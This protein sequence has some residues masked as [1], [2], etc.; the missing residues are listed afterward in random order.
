MVGLRS[1]QESVACDVHV[2]QLRHA[3]PSGM[4]RFNIVCRLQSVEKHQR[5]ALEEYRRIASQFRNPDLQLLLDLVVRE[6]EHHTQLL[7]RAAAGALDVLTWTAGNGASSAPPSPE[8]VEALR[9]LSVYERK[10]AFQLQELASCE[11]GVGNDAMCML[12]DSFARD[13]AK[14]VQLLTHISRQ[15]EAAVQ[16]ASRQ[17]DVSDE[18]R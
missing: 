8:L 4:A 14:H 16:A 7:R 2:D 10:C 18:P 15:L 12:L 1:N 9:A 3:D 6:C 17:L 5:A 11:R 13:C